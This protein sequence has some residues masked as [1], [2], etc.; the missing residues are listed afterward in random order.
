MESKQATVGMDLNS[1]NDVAN[2]IAKE[3][4]K[5][6]QGIIGTFKAEIANVRKEFTSELDSLTHNLKSNVV[7]INS[8]QSSQSDRIERLEDTVARMQRNSELVVSGIPVMVG[9][10]CYEIVARIASSIGF[11]LA[12]NSIS[13]F[14][15]NKSGANTS[16]TDGNAMATGQ[17]QNIRRSHPLILIKFHSQSDKSVFI[18]KYLNYKSLSLK[19]IGF[20]S[21]Q[22]VYIKE[23]LTP[24]NYK[25]FQRCAQAKRENSISKFHTKNGICY[26]ALPSSKTL[27]PVY[28][29]QHINDILGNSG[30]QTTLSVSKR[31]QNKRKRDNDTGAQQ[32]TEPSPGQSKKR[33]NQRNI[34][35]Q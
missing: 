14:R 27:T 18:G 24:S 31:Q 15:L 16:R 32:S 11:D 28:S 26:V 3:N 19:D 13:A 20:H 21:D 22:R 33:R 8:A 23:N 2:Y 12:N 34:S 35:K 6:T 1:F 7:E 17:Q 29:I 5:L 4:E 9:E 10:S 30:N 25:I